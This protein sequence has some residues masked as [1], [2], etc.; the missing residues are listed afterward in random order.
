[1]KKI[2]LLLLFAMLLQPCFALGGDSIFEADLTVNGSACHLE[3][4]TISI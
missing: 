1:M 2:V 3:L 4:G